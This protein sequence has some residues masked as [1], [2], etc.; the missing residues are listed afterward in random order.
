MEDSKIRSIAAEPVSS[1]EERER[2]SREL[3]KLEKGRLL[4]SQFNTSKPRK[5]PHNVTIL[6]EQIGKL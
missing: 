3:E 1:T 6:E 4:L 2:L 5:S